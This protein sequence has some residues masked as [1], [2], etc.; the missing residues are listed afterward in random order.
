MKFEKL[1]EECKPSMYYIYGQYNIDGYDS[2][3][4]FQ[5]TIVWI[6]RDFDKIESLDACRMQTAIINRAK[7]LCSHLNFYD[8]KIK[9]V[10]LM[11][12]PDLTTDPMNGE[13]TDL[14]IAH[15]MIR[16]RK[17]LS[18]KAFN[19][20]SSKVKPSKEMLKKMKKETPTRR[21][22]QKELKITDRPYQNAMKEIK[23]FLNDEGIHSNRG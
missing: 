23:G 21:D 17:I 13:L 6:L 15:L 1:I 12:V 8:P 14:D 4:L 16:A 10:E 19:V 2:D 3:D 9:K 18:E 7:W 5:E 20:L 11:D 22:I